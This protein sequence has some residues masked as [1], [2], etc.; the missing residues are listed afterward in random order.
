MALLATTPWPFPRETA[1]N[2][3]RLVSANFMSMLS[4]SAPG[5][6][7]KIKGVVLVESL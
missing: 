3:L 2:Y 6:S 5:E 7:T 1:V 4:G